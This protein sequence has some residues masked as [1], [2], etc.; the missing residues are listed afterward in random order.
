MWF[1]AETMEDLL[2]SY[3]RKAFQIT[4]TEWR[5]LSTLSF[6][7]PLIGKSLAMWTSIDQTRVSQCLSKLRQRKL[8]VQKTDESDR[9][10]ILI[11]LT[12]RGLGLVAKVYPRAAELESKLLASLSP[13]VR[14]ALLKAVDVLEDYASTHQ[15]PGP[16][17]SSSPTKSKPS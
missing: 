1:I 13:D 17:T 11:H 15:L 7:Q 16:Q 14:E 5:I 12:P 2:E 9:R 8:V 4:R 10:N 6:R 3:Y